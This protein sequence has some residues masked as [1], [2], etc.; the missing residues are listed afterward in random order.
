MAQVRELV[1]T[2]GTSERIKRRDEGYLILDVGYSI[3]V[4]CK[5]VSW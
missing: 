5:R 1:D 2:Y 3:P 4:I